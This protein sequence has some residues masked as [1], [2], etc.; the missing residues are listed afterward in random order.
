M[1][2]SLADFRHMPRRQFCLEG[3]RIGLGIGLALILTL[4]RIP[5]TI[6]HGYIGIIPLLGGKFKQD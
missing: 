3:L 5:G 4:T 1:I 6:H 2:L